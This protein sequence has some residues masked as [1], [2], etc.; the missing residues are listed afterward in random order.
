MYVGK[1]KL[2]GF[3]LGAL[4]FVSCVKQYNSAVDEK[5][6]FKDLKLEMSFEEVS[7]RVRNLI[8]LPYQPY[9]FIPSYF[10]G[11]S[12][13]YEIEVEHKIYGVVLQF[14]NGKLME[15]QCLGDDNALAPALFALYGEKNPERATL[16][17]DYTWKGENAIVNYSHGDD[18]YSCNIPSHYLKEHLELPQEAQELIRRQNIE[19]SLFPSMLGSFRIYANELRS[20]SYERA[21]EQNRNK[22]QNA[23]ADL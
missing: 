2:L 19:L 5:Y 17:E 4:I 21:K 18:N 7:S 15:I 1:I 3:C 11:D 23:A 10:V 16:Y 20:Q 6:G 8:P 12:T 22:A 9:D 13:Y 14:Y